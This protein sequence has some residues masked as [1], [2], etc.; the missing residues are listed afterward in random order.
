MKK[1]FSQKDKKLRE[2][3]K[4]GGR[5]ASKNDFMAVLRKATKTS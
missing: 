2:W 4:K 1:K 5:E 3:L